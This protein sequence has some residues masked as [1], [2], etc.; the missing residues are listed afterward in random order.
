MKTALLLTVLLLSPA[1]EARREVESFDELIARTRGHIESLDALQAEAEKPFLEVAPR[2]LNHWDHYL[3]EYQRVH[4]ELKEIA[5]PLSDVLAGYLREARQ[6][7]ARARSIT[8]ENAC[9]AEGRAAERA[10][11]EK[12][13]MVKRLAEFLRP[14]AQAVDSLHRRAFHTFITQAQEKDFSRNLG[15][16][17][18][19]QYRDVAL[20]AMFRDYY[21]RGERAPAPALY[22]LGVDLDAAG[23]WAQREEKDLVKE[24]VRVNSL[25]LSCRR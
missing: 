24:L 13:E 18:Q 1:A 11:L 20:L 4:A 17:F 23:H 8:P 9:G 2:C 5:L 22:Q 6:L 14:A 3:A 12:R 19:Y 15:C 7:Q 16:L 25:R 21:P 10:I